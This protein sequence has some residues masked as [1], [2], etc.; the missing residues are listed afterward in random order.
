MVQAC[1]QLNLPAK[2]SRP[3]AS[4]IRP[5]HLDRDVAAVPG[6]GRG[7]RSPCRPRRAGDRCGRPSSA[8]DS[9][10]ACALIANAPPSSPPSE[11]PGGLAAPPGARSPGFAAE[12]RDAYSLRAGTE[13]QGAAAFRTAR[14]GAW[15]S[16]AP[17]VDVAQ[18]LDQAGEVDLLVVDIARWLPF[19]Q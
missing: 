16:E 9:R 14:G 11:N 17:G 13:G 10:A 7:K 12:L 5:Q 8:A 3:S 2:R 1:G 18:E 15:R 4:E 6:R 19:G